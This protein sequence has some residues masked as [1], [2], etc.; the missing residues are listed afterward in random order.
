MLLVLCLRVNLGER[1]WFVD[2]P[3][4]T[5]IHLG[6]EAFNLSYFDESSELILRSGDDEVTWWVDLPSLNS[7]VT[8]GTGNPFHCPHRIHLES[9]SWESSI[10]TRHSFSNRGQDPKWSLLQVLWEWWLSIWM[11]LSWNKHNAFLAVCAG[12]SALQECLL[13][14]WQRIGESRMEELKDP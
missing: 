4:L 11:A 2:L 14:L 1:E 12:S 7:L 9:V 3:E 10:T 6:E 13:R 5:I 8:E